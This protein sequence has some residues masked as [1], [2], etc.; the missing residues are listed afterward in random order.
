[1]SPDGPFGADTLLGSL[2]QAVIATDVPGRVHYWNREAEKLYGWTADEALGREVDALIVPLLPRSLGDEI[3]ETLRAGGQWSGG[4]TVHRKD[5]SAFA[6]LVTDTG[7]YDLSGDLV[8]IIGVSADLGRALQP[9]LAQ[10][11]DAALIL[12]AEGTIGFLSPAASRLFGWS[13][14]A[15]IGTSL[16][17]LIHPDDRVLAIEHYRNVIA[18]SAPRPE[19]ECRVLRQDGSW[20]WADVLLTN[21]LHDPAVRGVVCNLRD[22]SERLAARA[23]RDALIEQLQTALTSRVEIEQ[24]KGLVAG[25]TG[26]DLHDA[27]TAL[28]RYARDSNRSLH[29]VAHEVINGAAEPPG[30]TT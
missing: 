13:D 6:A 15:V 7:I 19:L 21:F 10:S 5:G 28:R 8:G 17:Q 20:C 27:F 29:D 30:A 25:R 2:G 24:A 3:M 18:S 26:L 23:E 14:G 11:S 4:F 1:M 22:V 16:W 12:T 9:L